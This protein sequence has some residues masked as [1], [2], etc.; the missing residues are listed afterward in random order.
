MTEATEFDSLTPDQVHIEAIDAYHLGGTRYS[1]SFELS[2]HDDEYFRSFVLEVDLAASLTFRI[3]QRVEDSILS[4][5][6][7]APDRHVSLE[8]GRR[9]HDL[10]PEGDSATKLDGGTLSKLFHIP[11]GPQYVIGDEGA[12]HV[13]DGG[14]WVAVPPASRRTLNGIHGPTPELVHACGN[15]GT[16][17]R[18]RGLSWEPIVLSDERDFNAIE[19]SPGG[20]VHLGGNGG[21]AL[22]LRDGELIALDAPVR[23]YFAIRSFNG[24][25]YWG[26]A[27]WGLYVQEGAALVPF[28][29]L[30]HALGMHASRERLVVAGWKEIFVFDGEN[31]D[32]FQ[33]GYDG[34]IVLTRVNMADFNS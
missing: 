16:L 27:N 1:V 7:L 33:L 32:G 22:T 28:R 31:W 5:V 20:E 6:S 4:H 23:D 18:L 8:L 14:A 15:G 11:G 13:R 9:L 34:N 24:R 26:D 21:T 10:T 3:R 30:H 2:D 19:V 12:C 29:G 17:Q 25:R